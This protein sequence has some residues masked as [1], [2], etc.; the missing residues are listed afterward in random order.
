MLP[1]FETQSEQMRRENLGSLYETIEF[2]LSRIL[3]KMEEVGFRVDDKTLRELDEQFTARIDELR[4]RIYEEAGEEFNILSPKQLGVILFEKLKLPF[5][6]KTKTGYSTD[7]E[8]LDR[9]R[10]Y[11]PVVPLILEYRNV[12]KLKSTYID[13]LLNARNPSDGRVRSRFNQ[14]LTATGRIS[15]P[16]LSEFSTVYC[17]PH[18]Q[19]LWHSQ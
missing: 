5:A 15:I 6:K 18:S 19:R 4:K 17:D 8:T 1:V 10:S 7:A 12:T 2:P 16:S 3:A 14:C 13:G 9:I 11:H